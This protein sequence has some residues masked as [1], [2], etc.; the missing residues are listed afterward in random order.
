MSSEAVTLPEHATE[1]SQRR[2]ELALKLTQTCPPHLADEIALVGSTAHGVADDESDLELNLWAESIPSL[3]ARL[4]WLRAAGATDIHAEDAPRA[5][6]SYWIG[7][8]FDEVA[9]EVGWQTYAALEA[10][11]EMILSGKAERKAL[12]FADIVVSALPLRTTGRLVAWQARLANYSDAVQQVII[13]AAVERWSGPG[14]FAAARRLAQ[15]RE[16]IA[17]TELLVEDLDMALRVLYAAHRRWEPSRKWTLT[18][19]R[20]FVHDNLLGRID[21]VLGGRSRWRSGNPLVQYVDECARFCAESLEKAP[22]SAAVNA[23]VRMMWAEVEYPVRFNAMLSVQSIYSPASTLLHRLLPRLRMILGGKLVS[24]YLYGSLVL[25]DYDPDI[26]DMD[27]LVTLTSDLTEAEF[28]AL[29]AMHHNLTSN[30]RWVNWEDRIEIAYVTVEALRTFKTETRP[31]AVISPGEPFHFKDAGKDWLLNWYIVREKGLTLFGAPPRMMIPPIS[32]AEYVEEVKAHAE[33]WRG[34]VNQ[35]MDLP[36]QAYAILTMCR[37]LY[38]VTFGEH[39]SKRK[40]AAWATELMPE[41]AST[42][43]NAFLWR[44]AAVRP[45]PDVDHRATVENTRRFV[46]DLSDRILK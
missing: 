29:E 18:L 39:V 11:L 21:A 40:A 37:A 31:L 7:F 33:M 12:V 6:D 45:Q 35:E 23:T 17:L 44:A 32:Q 38:A 28:A 2:A 27:L 3:G 34:W 14:A 24:V 19:A 15:R 26:S 20:Q 10:A 43:E 42:I 8:E 25:G 1:A 4:E 9:G 5:D 13:T 41:W 36:F 16:R 30:K 46:R 22:P